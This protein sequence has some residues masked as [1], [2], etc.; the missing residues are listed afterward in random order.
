MN[1]ISERCEDGAEECRLRAWS[2]VMPLGSIIKNIPAIIV[3]PIKQPKVVKI[4]QDSLL[5]MIGG[6]RGRS[7]TRKILHL[8][9]YTIGWLGSC[10][11]SI[12]G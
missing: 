7:K 8:D 6:L 9:R 5:V 3:S 11:L 10:N 2:R 4:V 1:G 12:Y